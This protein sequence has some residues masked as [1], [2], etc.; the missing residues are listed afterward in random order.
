MTRRENPLL[1]PS[2]SGGS[3]TLSVTVLS[4]PTFGGERV[5]CR[6]ALT[7]EQYDKSGGRAAAAAVDKVTRQ[8]D[9]Y[10]GDRERSATYY[11]ITYEVVFDDGDPDGG[12]RPMRPSAERE[13]EV[14]VFQRVPERIR[15]AAAA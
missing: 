15:Q 1:Q 9:R 12:G 6:L 10:V 13:A 8:V 7:A 11:Y 14:V 3:E 5:S 4:H 2:K